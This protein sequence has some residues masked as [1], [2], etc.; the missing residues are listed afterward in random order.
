MIIRS[1]IFCH[2]HHHCNEW[3]VRGSKN[4]LIKHFDDDRRELIFSVQL[5]LYNVTFV[6]VK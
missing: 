6:Y 5:I 4:V 2:H 3:V 1:M